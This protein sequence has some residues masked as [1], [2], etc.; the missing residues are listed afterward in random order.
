[1][2]II[3]SALLLLALVPQSGARG[4][5]SGPAP[6]PVDKYVEE[7]AARGATAPVASPGSLYT[8]GKSFS[9]LARDPRSSQ[10]DDLV[11]ILVSDQASAV[12]KGTTNTQRKSSSKNSITAAAGVLKA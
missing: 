3:R 4:K 6:T 1:M 11:T 2:R 7:A 5:K 9:D 8:P 10:L 12:A